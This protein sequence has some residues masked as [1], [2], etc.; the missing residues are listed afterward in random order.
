[1]KPFSRSIFVIIWVA[2]VVHA[3]QA[4]TIIITPFSNTPIDIA[5]ILNLIPASYAPAVM[6]AASGLALISLL[7]IELAWYMRLLLLL[8]QQSLIAIACSGVLTAVANGAYSDG[9]PKPGIHIFDDQIWLIAYFCIHAY[10][11]AKR[12]VT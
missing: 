9:T 8:P 1:M 11:V 4:I 12:A 10:S 7:D 3:M 5:S 2:L 6:L